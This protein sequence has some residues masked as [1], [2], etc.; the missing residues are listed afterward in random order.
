M[1]ELDAAIRNEANY[2]GTE[3]ITKRRVITLEDVYDRYAILNANDWATT[4]TLKMT[5]GRL[6]DEEKQYLNLADEL[7]RIAKTDNFRLLKPGPLVSST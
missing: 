2:D 6:E 1:P 7:L 3:L 4:L 5:D